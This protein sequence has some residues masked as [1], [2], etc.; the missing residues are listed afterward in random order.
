[1]WELPGFPHM[2]GYCWLLVISV[3]GLLLKFI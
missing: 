3:V 2:W 1:V